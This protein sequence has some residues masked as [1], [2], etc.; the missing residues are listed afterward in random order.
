MSENRELVINGFESAIP[1]GSSKTILIDGVEI[2][3]GN[4]GYFYIKV[5]DED[6]I[7]RESKSIGTV[8]TPTALTA[9]YAMV[10]DL[11]FTNLFIRA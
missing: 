1:P 4:L 8:I 11:K 10:Y 9:S 6:Q 5:I 2:G 7:I 3:S